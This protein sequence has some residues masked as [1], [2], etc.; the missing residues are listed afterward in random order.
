MEVNN[1]NAILKYPGSKWSYAE[2]ITSHF[3]K[4][5]VYLEPYFGSGAVF[6][7]KS[8]SKFE[9]IN[10]IDSQVINFFKA[11]RD[12]PIDLARAVYYTP[13]ARE[14][15][16]SIQE[17]RAGQEIHLTGECVEDARRFAVRCFQGFGSKLADLA[18]WKNTKQSSGPVNPQVWGKLPDVIIEAAQRLKNAQIENRD[19]VKLVREYNNPDCLIYADPPYLGNVRK[20]KRIYRKE[21]MMPE[22]HEEL[23]WA[24]KKHKGMVVLSGYDNDLYNTT[25]KGWDKASMAGHA[26]GAKKRTETIWMNYPNQLR[27]Y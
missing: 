10:D 20:N 23:L 26:D 24:L 17:E 21:M 5:K 22:E 2:W 8:K 14:E 18:G 25:L 4:H 27:L 16:M 1:I 6:F 19:A 11:C 13:F 15:Y 7:K 12:Y 3:P 9:T